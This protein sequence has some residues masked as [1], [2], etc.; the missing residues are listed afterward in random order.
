MLIHDFTPE[1]LAPLLY[2]LICS[3]VY[4]H[5][6]FDD[7]PEHVKESYRRDA[8]RLIEWLQE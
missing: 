6:A 1:R 7:L 8:V 5:K 2:R 4:R 3:H